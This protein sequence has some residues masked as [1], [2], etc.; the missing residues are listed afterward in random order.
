MRRSSTI[1]FAARLLVLVLLFEVN[2]F[3]ASAHAA[4]PAAI[5]KQMDQTAADYS[6][7]ESER[8]VSIDKMAKLEHD[9]ADADVVT[10]QKA[11]ALK[12]RVAYLYKTGGLGDLLQGLIISNDLSGFMR[13]I[14]LLELAGNR[15]T[16]LVEGL[17]ITQRRAD[18]LKAGLAATIARQKVLGDQLAEK[19][20]QLRAQFQG[21]K[22]AQ[23]VTRYGNFDS[24]TLPIIGPV[25]FTNTWGAPRPGGRRHKGTDVMAPCGAPVVAVTNG[26]I[27]DMHSGGL[28]GIM[29]WVRAPNGDVFFYAHL[30]RYAPSAHQGKSVTTGEL[31]GFNGNTGD[32]RGGA[33]HVHFEWHPG[34]GA[35]VNSYPLLAAV[36]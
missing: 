31:I 30:S 28:G 29:S 36:R 26:T 11:V 8:A 22:S 2:L 23:R 18:L 20:Q 32:A 17:K 4:D 27:S 34:G 5:Q 7:I 3:A 33:C 21:A 6:R 35:A 19:A 14:E 16:R 9:L 25:A 24:F 15:D 10:K 1:S 13:R 12:A